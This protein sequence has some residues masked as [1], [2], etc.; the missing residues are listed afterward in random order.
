MEQFGEEREIG[1]TPRKEKHSL[2][3]K[4][5]YESMNRRPWI[6]ILEEFYATVLTKD[7]E[8]YKLDGFHVMVT[9][10][11]RY[12][13][14]KEYKRSIILEEVVK[15]WNEFLTKKLD[16]FACILLLVID[17]QKFHPPYRLIRLTFEKFM[18]ADLNQI[19]LKIMS[20]PLKISL[21]QLIPGSVRF[22]EFRK[23]AFHDTTLYVSLHV[24]RRQ[25]SFFNQC[26]P[27]SVCFCG[28][29]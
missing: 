7:G 11:D 16:I 2:A 19:A 10:V 29:F 22:C 13:T 28:K 1:K 9:A 27:T 6:K 3:S 21:I 23:A 4:N 26:G 20:L 25:I 18:R 14:E 8:D 17:Y 5:G 15:V 24:R 12:L